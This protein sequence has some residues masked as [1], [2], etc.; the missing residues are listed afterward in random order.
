MRSLSE[1]RMLQCSVAVAGLVP[2]IG[3]GWG[4][5]SRHLGTPGVVNHERYL[6]GLLVAIGLAFWSTVSDIEHKTGQFRLLT[7][8]VFVG[9]LCRL[10]GVAI[11]DGTSWSIMAPLLMELLVAPLLCLWQSSFDA[12]LRPATARGSF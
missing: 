8:L 10:I 11:G 4:V 6:S 12:E 7:T 1:K 5:L 9:G 3:G 2:V